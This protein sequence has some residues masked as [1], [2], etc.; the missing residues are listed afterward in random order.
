MKKN[1][2][3]KTPTASGIFNLT[4]TPPSKLLK[5]TGIFGLVVLF[6][7]SLSLIFSACDN[8]IGLGDKVNVVDPTIRVPS[9]AGDNAP[10]SFISGSDGIVYLDINAPADGFEI[11]EAIMLIEWIDENGVVQ[12]AEVP[13]YFDEEKGQWAFPIDTIAL[14]IPD[15]QI[16]ANVTAKDS[17]GRSTTTT[18]MIFMIKNLPPQI[19]L[20]IPSVKGTNFDISHANPFYDSITGIKLY[21]T[22]TEFLEAD[23]LIIGFDFMGMATDAAGIK[24]GFPKIMI[25]PADLH[26][27]DYDN[28]NPLTGTPK[29]PRYGTWRSAV[30]NNQRDGMT[31]TR[32]SWPMVHLVSDSSAPGGYRLPR[33]NEIYTTLPA[34]NYRIKLWIQDI[35]GRDNYY[36][37]R[38]DNKA[39]PGGTTVPSENHPNKFLEI[40]YTSIDTPI[41]NIRSVP[42]FYNGVGNFTVGLTINATSDLDMNYTKAYITNSDI[43]PTWQSDY[44]NLIPGVSGN[45]QLVVTPEQVQEWKSRTENTNQGEENDTLYVNVQVK[46]IQDNLGPTVYRSFV[47]DTTPPVITFDRPVNLSK[48][49]ASGDLLGGNYT[50][51]YPNEANPRWVVNAV[52]VGGTNMET[53][54]LSKI[55]YHIGKLTTSDENVNHENRQAIYN[56]I[57]WTD[58]A[59]DTATPY[60]D[61]Y[62]GKWRG[63]IY[64]FTYNLDFN[65]FKKN[66]SSLIQ[67][68]TG[69]VGFAHNINTE[70]VGKTRFYIPFYVKVVDV[71]GNYSI[72]HYK[73]SVDPDL[74]IPLVSFI[75][76]TSDLTVGG[77]VRLS[78]SASDNNWI[79]SVEIRIRKGVETGYYIPTIPPT[80]PIYQPPYTGANAGNEG[81]FLA[82]IIGDGPLVNWYFN[83]NTDGYLDPPEGS[84]DIP[85]LFE[86]RAWDT[87][88]TIHYLKDG[89][90]VTGTPEQLTIP[91][92]AGVP[93]I[94]T[95]VID[96]NKTIER[97]F[98]E[99][100]NASG[101]FTITTEITDDLKVMDIV[102]TI[103]R[104]RYNILTAGVPQ[105]VNSAIS[106]SS[107]Q[108]INTRKGYTLTITVDTKT[109][110][111]SLSN[112]GFGQT[113]YLDLQIEAKDG[114]SPQLLARNSYT[115]GVDNFY[116]TA[117][118]LTHSNASSGKFLLEGIAQDYGTGSGAIQGLERMLIYFEKA[119]VSYS[120]GSRVVSRTG[121]YVNP[122]GIEISRSGFSG[123]QDPF[124]N[125]PIYTTGTNAGVSSGWRYNQSMETYANVRL[126]NSIGATSFPS[127]FNEPFPI[128]RQIIKTTGSPSVE[129]KQWESPHAMVI[130][131]PEFGTDLDEDGTSGEVWS[132]LV[133]KEWQAW[134]DTEASG[135]GD[136]P[137]WVHYVIM[138][139]AGNA[140]RYIREI[141]IENNRPYIET[142]NLGTDIDGIN[143]VTDGLTE[144]QGAGVFPNEFRALDFVVGRTTTGNSLINF[145]PDPA[146]R[147][148]NNR[149]GLKLT[150]S[151]G[152]GLK[153]WKI[154]YVTGAVTANATAMVR[155][156]V[157]TILN[158]G[159]T[160]FRKFGAAQNYEGTTFVATSRGEGTGTVT[161]YT[162]TSVN[163]G[164]FGLLDNFLVIKN[165]ITSTEFTDK[166]IPDSTKYTAADSAIMPSDKKIGDIRYHYER[167]FIIKIWDNTVQGEVEA[168][169]LAHA[170]IVAMDID[171]NDQYTPSITAAPFGQKYV[172]RTGTGAPTLENDKDKILGAV[173]NYNENIVMESVD[174]ADVRQGYVQ[175]AAHKTPSTT[176]PDISG[177]IIF[178]GKA[179]DNQRIQNITVTIPGFNSGSAFEVASLGSG[180]LEGK[181]GTGWSFVVLDDHLT[182][183]Y[184]HAAN[185]KFTWDSSQV[186]NQVAVPTIIFTV[187]DKPV[188]PN[189]STNNFAVNIVPYIS[190]ITTRLSGAYGAAPSAFARSSTGWYPVRESE[191]ITIR[192]FNLGTT[193][194]N[195]LTNTTVNIGGTVSGNTAPTGG[196]N[197][198]PTVVSGNRNA[199]SLNVGNTAMSGQLTVRV[200][201]S[202]N[203]IN[204]RTTLL[205]SGVTDNNANRQNVNNR[206]AYNWEPNNVNNN[207]LTNER[208]I[209]IWSAGNISNLDALEYPHFS[210]SPTG[211]RFMAYNR[212][213]G[214][215]YR[216]TNDNEVQVENSTNRYLN[217][218]TTFGNNGLWYIGT[219]NQTAQN[220]NSYAIHARAGSNAAANAD[221]TN[222]V[223]IL[224][225]GAT[226]ATLLPNRV[227]VPK[228]HAY[229]TAANSSRV[230]TSYYDESL[231]QINFHYGTITGTQATNTG[232]GTANVANWARGGDFANH[233]TAPQVVAVSGSTHD[234]SIHTAVA[235]LSNGVPVIAWY[236]PKSDSIV[237]SNGNAIGTNATSTTNTDTWQSNAVVIDT[238][239]GSYVDMAVDGVN[240]VHLA[241][242]DS[243]NGGLHYAYIP[244][245]SGTGLPNK[246]AIERARVDTFLGAGTNIMINIRLEGGGYRPYISY[247]HSSYAT[248]RSA[249]RIAWPI[250]PLS[251]TKYTVANNTN[252][253]DLFLGTWEVMSVPIVNAPIT[254]LY[255]TF[256]VSNGVPTSVTNWVKPAGINW[257]ATNTANTI[258]KSVVIGFMAGS[259]YEG[260]VL[261]ADIPALQY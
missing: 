254:P 125:K 105:I 229:D 74:D 215:L 163:H 17:S 92:S 214:V 240:N 143:G 31:A 46:D 144:S 123:A 100:V 117:S 115:I 210:V 248:T 198:T 209:Y 139:K 260:A 78:G 112:L 15:G 154:S 226:T 57:V 169:Q 233:H 67:E 51:L 204:N 177:N 147:V 94:S 41:A 207:M 189:T 79:H 22:L 98:Q 109:N 44:Y 178:F 242:Y 241:Y 27:S 13:G 47:F 52:D 96:K 1:N 89:N 72:V 205:N 2:A 50:I 110:N 190:E 80:Q 38:V 121:H 202:T 187:N 25:W 91:F 75:Y 5:K 176:T 228:V 152:N 76:P 116:P 199:I 113:G 197:I 234:G 24:N 194:T 208:K 3:K 19:E 28:G 16:K 97:V 203:S 119:S 251:G 8:M 250:T 11:E 145:S 18:D 148:R 81:W 173:S 249:V 82:N 246:T 62:G 166:A 133:D 132:G 99:G 153:N 235:T 253:S 247:I 55:Y 21:D 259:R 222:K 261:K 181:S 126:E 196:T 164:E 245:N 231:N 104:V 238:G 106:L 195:I 42:S 120:S 175:Y 167:R 49:F 4:P 111:L 256:V 142:L 200:S 14:G 26:S 230:V 255:S 128:L 158:V 159:N 227:R 225:I 23:K 223:R 206:I 43:N 131:N 236:S 83:I 216:N 124:Y 36:P 146:F 193:G 12:K 188:S 201:G 165:A 155:G 212:T 45:Y 185:W 127:D 218:T 219:S 224:N 68:H 32:F 85:V 53:W 186:T 29:D 84:A 160:D 179:E 59:L 35:Y 103:N 156:R 150:T 114:N 135:F 171:N 7:I 56:G 102:A 54:G 66:H 137:I 258:E 37:N 63:S 95:P 138:D 73:L 64:N 244:Y 243:N 70:T 6:I 211:T 34:G 9:D 10:G 87:K 39:G 184:G 88:D 162:E 61:S 93:R 172:L 86:A 213:T 118:I 48:V 220:N 20:N 65:D 174:G 192:G 237:F 58:T 107:E 257:P 71:A 77:E 122:R 239:K 130:D 60:I 157:Y 30:V 141:F 232:T 182:L 69:L 129:Y 101:I 108:T 40:V 221:G 168:E 161:Q 33:G 140:T 180:K 90:S 170:V 191:V 134:M 136:G 151:G 217:I 149:L 252:N 183:N